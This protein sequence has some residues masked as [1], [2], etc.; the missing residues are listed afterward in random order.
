MSVWIEQNQ[1]FLIEKLVTVSLA[2]SIVVLLNPMDV[3]YCYAVLGHAHFAMAH[4]Y[5][6]KA[7]KITLPKIGL[8]IV[9][10]VLFFSIAWRMQESFI[11]FV[12]LF[13]LFHNFLDEF[14]LLGTKPDPVSFFMICL[15]S[16]M[17]GF[18]LVENLWFFKVGAHVYYGMAALYIAFL[19]SVYIKE[20]E[21]FKVA[22]FLYLNLIMLVLLALE[23][24]GGRPF[25]AKVVGFMIISHYITWYIVMGLKFYERD[26][27]GFNLYMKEVMALNAVIITV[28]I[29][30]RYHVPGVDL[31]E[32]YLFH[33]VGFYVWTLMHLITTLRPADY[34][35]GL[36]LQTG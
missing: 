13:F 19:A 34:K 10:L 15:I 26:K 12:A 11:F 7:G 29:Y 27:A 20:R 5:Q 16:V 14:K 33:Y 1:T 2:L 21:R 30:V 35:Q 6:G 9:A 4:L 28:F 23:F 24:S 8:Y 32:K 31:V 17:L 3:I 18:W 25:A 22:Y 36:G